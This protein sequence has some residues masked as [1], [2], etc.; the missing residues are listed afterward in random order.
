MLDDHIAAVLSVRV[1]AHGTPPHLVAHA[2]QVAAAHADALDELTRRRTA[3]PD[4]ARAAQA[5]A[6]ADLDD[7]IERWRAADDT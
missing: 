1:R 4:Q 7:P 2:D 5:D 6:A 3:D